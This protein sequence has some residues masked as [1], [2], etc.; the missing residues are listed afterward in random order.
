MNGR[1]VVV[2]GTNLELF[3]QHACTLHNNHTLTRKLRT[4]LYVSSAL[5]P[6]AI[7]YQMQRE[8]KGCVTV[9]KFSVQL[10]EN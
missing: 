7:E 5:R 3:K 2:E 8:G 1:E 4:F 6:L 10:I 9:S